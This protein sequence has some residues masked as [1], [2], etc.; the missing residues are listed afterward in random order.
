MAFRPRQAADDDALWTV[1]VPPSGRP[2]RG[3]ELLFETPTLVRRAIA[4]TLAAA[5][6]CGRARSLR[7]AAHRM[8]EAGVGLP[9]G[10]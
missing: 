7:A 4:A 3:N 6:R 9:T 10:R 2:K 5:S 8:Y 1:G